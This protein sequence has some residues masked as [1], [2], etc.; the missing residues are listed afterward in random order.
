MSDHD[1]TLAVLNAG[2]VEWYVRFDEGR[3]WL[4]RSTSWRWW[5]PSF[6]GTCPFG[7]E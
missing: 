1:E 3:M 4:R 5:L 2:P 6:I 7:S